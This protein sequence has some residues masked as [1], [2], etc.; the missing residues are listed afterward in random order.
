M[1]LAD[2]REMVTGERHAQERRL[3]ARRPGADRQRQEIEAGLVYPDD[4][5]PSV[6]RFFFSAGQRSSTSGDLG[7]VALR[8][9]RDRL[10]HAVV[11]TMERR[12]LTCAGW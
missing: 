1:T 6:G 12:R 11:Q 10:L 4:G 5:R 3:S 9:P 2:G 8:R 7:L